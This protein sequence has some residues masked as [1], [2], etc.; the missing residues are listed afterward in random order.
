MDKL[1]GVLLLGT[2]G[3]IPPMTTEHMETLCEINENKTIVPF[4]FRTHAH[5]LGE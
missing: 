1:A 5:G 3:L 2:S 4:A